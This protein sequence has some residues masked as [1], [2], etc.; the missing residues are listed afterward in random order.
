M[1]GSRV[2]T[3]AKEIGFWKERIDDYQSNLGWVPNQSFKR[4]TAYYSGF[5]KDTTPTG[6]VV[7]AVASNRNNNGNTNS[8][9]NTSDNNNK[10]IAVFTNEYFSGKGL[11]AADYTYF[12]PASSF[13]GFN[14]DKARVMHRFLE[15]TSTSHLAAHRC[16]EV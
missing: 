12:Y 16:P 1:N 10:H 11:S 7:T 5:Y 15:Q 8:Y 6:Q 4:R 13:T 3:N 9:Y 2:N 14:V